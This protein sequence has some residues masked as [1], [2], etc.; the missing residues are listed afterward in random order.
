MIDLATRTWIWHKQFG[1]LDEQTLTTVTA[2]AIDP[3]NSKIA[4]HAASG[5]VNLQPESTVG[6]IFVLDLLSGV[7]VSGLMKMTHT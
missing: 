1:E 2:L 7:A 3:A 4:C 5:S 6:Y